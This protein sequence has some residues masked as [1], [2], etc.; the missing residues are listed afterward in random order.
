MTRSDILQHSATV[1]I[2]VG[3][4]VLA[5]QHGFLDRHRI[6]SLASQISSVMKSRRVVLV[7]SGA[8]GAGVG[9]LK[10]G[11]RPTDLPHLQ[12]CAAVG[13]SA[14]MQA[15]R[16][17]FATHQIEPAQILLTAS[18]FEARS[19][20]L[21]ARLTLVTLFEYGC[22]P[23]INEN[24]TVSVAEIK[25]GDNDHLAALVCNL[26]HAPLLV[27]LTNVDGLFTGDPRSDPSAQL[28]PTVENIEEVLGL[29]AATKS[30][31]GTGGMKSKL[32]AAQIATTAGASVIMANGSHDGI[33]ER[34]FAGDSVG[35]LFLPKKEAL[36]ARERWLA[37][38]ARPKGILK[39]DDG[40]RK[41]IVTDGRSLLPVGIK[42]LEG[43][44]S[45]GDVVSVQTLEGVELARGLT[46][47]SNTEAE[48]MRGLTSEQITRALGKLPYVEMIHRDNMVTM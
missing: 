3:T 29:A 48:K 32:K 43:E 25:F 19:R 15:Y 8:I 42:A 20:Y 22:V 38:T 24:D 12:A 46:N 16:E 26:L 1:V 13:Q 33:I 10:L 44:F 2:K 5:D 6:R 9:V 34:V 4:N 45:K 11:K 28:V 7:S 18:D 37:F 17:E 36:S 31:L 21:N 23:I 30:Q 14:L 41:A 35:T 27:L 47:Y 40:A 39:V